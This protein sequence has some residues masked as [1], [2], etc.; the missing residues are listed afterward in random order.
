MMVKSITMGWRESKMRSIFKRLSSTP[1]LL[2]SKLYDQDDFYPA[3]LKD[4]GKCGYEVIIESP[5]I[6]SRRL[7]ALLPT[8]EKLKS[9]KVKIIINTRDPEA[10]DDEYLCKEARRALSTLQHMGVHVLYT[11]KHHRKLAIL[12]RSILYE[13]S[14]NILSQNDSAEVMRRIESAQLAWEMTRFI[15]VDMLT[16]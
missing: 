8:I 14:L 2:G 7:N 4:L 1:D 16:R 15:N 12:D 5:F 10:Q 6:T 3:F 11:A 9:R 13:G